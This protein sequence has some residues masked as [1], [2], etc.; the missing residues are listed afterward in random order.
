MGTI[1]KLLVTEE[2]DENSN[3][4]LPVRPLKISPWSDAEWSL[5]PPIVSSSILEIRSGM[6]LVYDMLMNSI[7]STRVSTAAHS[8]VAARLDAYYLDFGKRISSLEVKLNMAQL[9]QSDVLE[10]LDAQQ[11]DIIQHTDSMTA[12]LNAQFE[13]TK[14]LVDSALS[15]FS[16][17]T[18]VELDAI[19]LRLLSSP[20]LINA[21]RDMQS[22]HS[23][24]SFQAVQELNGRLEDV[25]QQLNLYRKNT[26]ELAE[27]I[28][29]NE[30]HFNQYQAR[31]GDRLRL[32]D[33]LPSKL[34]ELEGMHQLSLKQTCDKEK[35]AQSEQAS[36]E[37][38]DALAA[39]KKE[40]GEL[41]TSLTSNAICGEKA[42]PH[43][44]DVQSSTAP[45][46]LPTIPDFKAPSFEPKNSL[47]SHG[48][49]VVESIS[50]DSITGNPVTESLT[51]EGEEMKRPLRR[52]LP[53][54]QKSDAQS[55]SFQTKQYDER[56]DGCEDRDETMVYQ[57]SRPTPE[58]VYLNDPE[59]YQDCHRSI[60]QSVNPHRYKSTVMISADKNIRPRS[61]ASQPTSAT[62]TIR[63]LIPQISAQLPYNS[64]LLQSLVAKLVPELLP[65]F[66]TGSDNQ[67]KEDDVS[68][69][70]LQERLASIAQQ[71]EPLAASVS[72]VMGR[73]ETLSQTLDA[74]IE[75]KVK[76][77]S[78]KVEKVDK[79]LTDDMLQK[80]GALV[81]KLNSKIELV[82]ESLQLC[83]SSHIKSIMDA[84]D[85]RDKTYATKTALFQLS[86][87]VAGTDTRI[88]L[89]EDTILQLC[90]RLPDETN[91]RAL[92]T[93]TDVVRE[94]GV[95]NSYTYD[96]PIT[97]PTN[98]SVNSELSAGS[99]TFRDQLSDRPS[100]RPRAMKRSTVVSA[101]PARTKQSVQ[102][103]QNTQILP[104][105]S[106]LAS[107][108]APNQ[109]E[110][111]IR[112][113]P[114]LKVSYYDTTTLDSASGCKENDQD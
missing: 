78:D 60:A 74:V 108:C 102:G 99:T 33:E 39:I 90:R 109:N 2:E 56:E 43:F 17:P 96:A 110:E 107:F 5:I 83:I 76:S 34:K 71:I 114:S 101:P 77:V 32:L 14:L 26:Q 3:L 91:L 100:K 97:V 7:S 48:H 105:Q 44:H 80:H 53:H 36:Q 63:E 79:A 45:S 93:F 42:C 65:Y 38:K 111:L 6:Q 55:Y 85:L 58:T 88:S 49:T 30:R 23:A 57:D 86:R 19:T 103:T 29:N 113:S 89:H 11:R 112:T 16:P 25:E 70:K 24:A 8:Q 21:L 87:S 73:M 92:G 59:F 67:E 95:E 40:L 9:R 94:L 20:V 75:S 18:D 62:L 41:R 22:E 28:A 72:V 69:V 106:H 66:R 10:K 104:G 84:L 51:C 15:K 1:P 27:I 54:T 68:P 64:K 12:K 50:R 31:I 82:R 4:S 61:A 35:Q 52:H 37:T 47:M 46:A 81:S 98:S 13:R